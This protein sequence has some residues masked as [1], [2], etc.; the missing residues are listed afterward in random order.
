VNAPHQTLKVVRDTHFHLGINHFLW[1]MAHDTEMQ[2][3]DAMGEEQMMYGHGAL[4]EE[5]LNEK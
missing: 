4:T 3:A 1:K 2:D 5:E